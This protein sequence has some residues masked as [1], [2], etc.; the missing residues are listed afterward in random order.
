VQLEEIE[1]E[2]EH[3]ND[4]NSSIECEHKSQINSQLRNDILPVLSNT[5]IEPNK[6]TEPVTATVKKEM[7]NICSF[8]RKSEKQTA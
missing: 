7:S 8:Q 6:S 3:L 1:A 4:N 2:V 5:S